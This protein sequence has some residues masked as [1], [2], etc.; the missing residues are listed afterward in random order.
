MPPCRSQN[1][2]DTI[3]FH[4]LD[5]LRIEGGYSVEIGVD[6]RDGFVECNTGALLERPGWDGVLIDAKA[7]NHYKA[8]QR[9]VVLESMAPIMDYYKPDVFSLDVDGNDY[10]L[11]EEA[12]NHHQPA[13]LIVEYN[14]QIDPVTI[15]RSI[16]YD[17]DFK[18]DNTSYFGASAGA[19]V[20]LAHKRG[21]KLV[22]DCEHVNLFFAREELLPTTHVEP[23]ISSLAGSKRPHSADD[24]KRQYVRV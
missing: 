4:L 13:I 7:I 8:V 17:R 2:E 10:W 19:M 20:G 18:W 3:L 11:L 14:A 15:S 16:P 12:L 6:E 5:M 21:Y 9:W 1:G 24:L 22:T 23:L